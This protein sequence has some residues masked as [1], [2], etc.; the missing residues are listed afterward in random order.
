M[1]S[2]LQKQ[3]R[4]RVPRTT[5][6]PRPIQRSELLEDAAEHDTL[7]TAI[8]CRPIVTPRCSQ[9]F[10]FSVSFQK[11]IAQRLSACIFPSKAFQ[12]VAFVH[13]NP[14][15]SL[16]YCLC[17]GPIWPT[18]HDLVEMHPAYHETI[19]WSHTTGWYCCVIPSLLSRPIQDLAFAIVMALQG[20][21][22]PKNS[23]YPLF[24]SQDSP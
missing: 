22:T 23:F 6:P 14:R 1:D 4:E 3:Q 5:L 2:R 20:G 9:C 17:L 11:L 19:L 8:H 15:T 21:S 13:E 10:N 18:Y 12:A 24:Y 7:P 16:A